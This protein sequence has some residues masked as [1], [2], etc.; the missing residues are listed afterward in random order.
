VGWIFPKE[1]KEAVNTPMEETSALKTTSL[2]S[3]AEMNFVDQC[4]RA[5]SRHFD[6][7]EL[8]DSQKE[9]LSL[10]QTHQNVLAMMPTGSGK[11]LLYALPALVWPDALIVVLSPLIALMRDQVL[12]LSRAGLSCVLFTSD[13]SD[14][15]RRASFSEV[16][17]GK[18]R[19]LFVSPE[20]FVMPSFQRLFSEKKPHMVVVDEAHCIVSWGHGFRPEYQLLEP[21]IRKLNPAHVLAL[22]AT[23]SQQSRA[24]I[25][26]HVFALP[27]KVT[28]YLKEPLASNIFVCSQRVYSE[29]QKREELIRILKKKSFAKCIVY[30][31]KRD[32]CEVMAKDLRTMGIHAVV[33]HAG[34]AKNLRN[35]AQSYLNNTTQSTVICATQAFGMGVDLPDVDIVVVFGYPANLEEMFQMFGRAGRRG[36]AAEAHLVWSGADPKKRL[37]QFEIGFPNRAKLDELLRCLEPFWQTDGSSSLQTKETLKKSMMRLG[38]KPEK[39]FEGFYAAL[40]YLGVCVPLALHTDVLEIQLESKTSLDSL[41]LDLPQGLT[42]RRFFLDALI[43]SLSNV[44]ASRRQKCG[45]CMTFSVP[46]LMDGLGWHFEQIVKVLKHYEGKWAFKVYSW[47]ELADSFE[48]ASRLDM[49][50]KKLMTWSKHRSHFFESLAEIDRFANAKRCR[51][52]QA[53]DFFLGRVGG[54]SA[55]PK[56][57][58]CGRCDLCAPAKFARTQFPK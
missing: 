44:D 22:T 54:A 55:N 10:L 25:K 26:E 38:H 34:M 56:V 27:E 45:I 28:D 2:H 24:T 47:S 48:F 5:A 57:S 29:D 31:S 51:L 37:F 17:S 30:F 12:R 7:A 14:E 1:I 49:R 46:L 52:I 58:V 3:N 18:A 36:S 15:E 6:H 13:Q 11:T 33:Y 19:I 16:R 9:V 42:Q 20:R 23:A 35:S 4:Q 32:T 8:R 39:E 53:K 50:R 21:Y 43:S 40:R 41:L